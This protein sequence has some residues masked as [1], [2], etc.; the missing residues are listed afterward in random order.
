[1]RLRHLVAPAMTLW[2]LVVG[3]AIAAAALGYLAAMVISGAQPVQRQLAEFKAKGVLKIAPERIRRL[4]ISG[5]GKRIILTRTD[6]GDWTTADGTALDTDAGKRISMAVQM[7]HTSGPVRDIP[8]EDLAQVDE[9]TF[10]LDPPRVTAT[11][12]D[13]RAIPVLTARFG[14]NNPDEVLQYLRVDGDRHLYLVSRF[15]GEE[16]TQALNGNL[17]Q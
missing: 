10:G 16:W 12:Y 1:V 13:G 11:F 2:R 5:T 4:E 17:Q 8:P 3:P 15:L 9:A 6:A 14:G 7:M